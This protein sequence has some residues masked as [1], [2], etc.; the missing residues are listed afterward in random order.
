MSELFDPKNI[1]KMQKYLENYDWFRTNYE[2]LKAEY[3][4]KYVAIKNKNYFDSDEDYIKLITRLKSTSDFDESI[5][6]DFVSKKDLF[7]IH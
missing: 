5:Y 6:T 2:K 4:G 1:Q 3:D 7:I